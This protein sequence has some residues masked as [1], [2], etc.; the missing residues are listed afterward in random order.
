MRLPQQ[1]TVHEN[2]YDDSCLAPLIEAYDR[3]R[4]AEFRIPL[5][6]QRYVREFGQLDFYGWSEDKA[7]QMAREER[8]GVSEFVRHHGFSLR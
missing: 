5:E 8:S 2:I 3:E 7:R 1:V 4:D 6:Q